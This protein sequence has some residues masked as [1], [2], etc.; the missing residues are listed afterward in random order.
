[1]TIQYMCCNSKVLKT[2]AP[3]EIKSG[4]QQ[5]CGPCSPMLNNVSFSA[6]HNTNSPNHLSGK[7]VQLK[8]ICMSPFARVVEQACN[9]HCK[10]AG[11]G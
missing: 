1:M 10:E 5:D 11:G 7:Q 4:T 9:M 6:R 3:E 8:Q 2:D